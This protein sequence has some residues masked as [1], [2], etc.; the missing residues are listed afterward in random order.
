MLKLKSPH[1]ISKA[2]VFCKR[3]NVWFVHFYLQVHYIY[4]A[5]LVPDI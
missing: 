2:V 4:S 5:F 1:K 3:N